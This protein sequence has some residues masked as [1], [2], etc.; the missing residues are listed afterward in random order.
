TMEDTAD[1]IA[2]LGNA[3][4]KGSTAGTSLRQML[5]SLAPTSKKAAEMMQELGLITKDGTNQ[6]FDAT[7]K[8]KSFAEITQILHDATA[9]LTPMQQEMAYKTIFQ[10]RAMASA[11]V[12]SRDGADAINQMSTEVSKTTAIDVMNKRLDNLDGSMKRFKASVQT[13]FIEQGA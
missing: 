8:L 7:G 12:L 9:K 13:A 3:G 1:A 4:I 6:F 10:N 11:I 2:V 5:L